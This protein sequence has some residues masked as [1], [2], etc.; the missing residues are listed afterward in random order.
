MAGNNKS[1]A[2]IHDTF[3]STNWHP[4]HYQAELIKAGIKMPV[5]KDSLLATL[6][7]DQ[8][9]GLPLPGRT[10]MV[11]VPHFGDH[12]L[13]IIYD[14]LPGMGNPLAQEDRSRLCLLITPPIM[15][16]DYNKF[17]NGIPILGDDVCEDAEVR[18]DLFGVMDGYLPDNFV[19]NALH[20]Q[21]ISFDAL[22]Y[23]LA[24]MS[25]YNNRFHVLGAKLSPLSSGKAN[26]AIFLKFEGKCPLSKQQYLDIP[27][28]PGNMKIRVIPEPIVTENSL[29]APNTLDIV[30]TVANPNDKLFD[31]AYKFANNLVSHDMR[32]LDLQL[33]HIRTD[34]ATGSL[35]IATHSLKSVN[36]S[37]YLQKAITQKLK[38][39]LM[40][41]YLV[42]DVA[43]C[44]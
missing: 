12:C 14:A 4:A 42:N 33:R 31:Y 7:E 18:E 23:H 39:G 16:F 20:V 24:N 21:H 36:L 34:K 41:E 26:I 5:Y 9:T 44:A 38:N 15:G 3:F 2:V 28:V 8:A 13:D 37:P 1:T 35:V 10:D 30:V 43:F 11:Y 22:Q 29:A 17:C 25:P 40:P 27:G 19:E 32:D 6:G